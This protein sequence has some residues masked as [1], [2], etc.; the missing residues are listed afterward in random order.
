M[1]SW[2]ERTFSLN[3]LSFALVVFSAHSA[4]PVD[5]TIW[6]PL[7]DVE[8]VPHVGNQLCFPLYGTL[9]DKVVGGLRKLLWQKVWHHG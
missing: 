8:G 6:P 7:S 2:E 9:H 3:H 5:G 1:H 4:L